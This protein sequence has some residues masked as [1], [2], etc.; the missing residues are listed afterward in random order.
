MENRRKSL[1]HGTRNGPRAGPV[2]RFGSIEPVSVANFVRCFSICTL[3][4]IMFEIPE[5]LSAVAAEAFVRVQHEIEAKGV[6]GVAFDVVERY[7]VTYGLW[8]ETKTCLDNEGM[9]WSDGTRNLRM[10]DLHKLNSSVA[11]I[12][13]EMG[14]GVTVETPGDSQPD[15]PDRTGESDDARSQPDGL[16]LRYNFSNKN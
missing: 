13:R 16:S 12:R 11:S 2:E 9:T 8:L 7:A 3:I 5:H 6:V 15:A 1:C 10:I 4:I 14:L